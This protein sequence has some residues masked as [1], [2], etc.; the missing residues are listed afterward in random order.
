MLLTTLRLLCTITISRKS[1]TT[2]ILTLYPSSPPLMPWYPLSTFCFY[3]LDPPSAYNNPVREIMQYP[4]SMPQHNAFRLPLGYSLCHNVILLQVDANQC[5]TIH[6]SSNA[7]WFPITEL[8]A[9]TG[10]YRQLL[11]PVL[12]ILFSLCLEVELLARVNSIFNFSV[13]LP[14]YFPQQLHHFIV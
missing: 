7:H 6:L 12:S 4:S 11:E 13:E 9:R 2:Q 1:S 3:E 8:T 14:Y 10:V 5:N